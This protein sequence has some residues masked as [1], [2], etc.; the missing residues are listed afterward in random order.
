[1]AIALSPGDT[2]PRE[3][4][5]RA[6]ADSHHSRVTGNVLTVLAMTIPRKTRGSENR[7]AQLA[8]RLTI[9]TMKPKSDWEPLFKHFIIINVKQ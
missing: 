5:G 4:W 2:A 6:L 7:P 8:G 3:N 9:I 1:M